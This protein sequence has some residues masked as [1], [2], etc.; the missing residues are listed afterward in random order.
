MFRKFGASEAI[1][2]NR[3]IGFMSDFF[4]AFNRVVGHKQRAT[5]AYRPQEND[6]AERMVHTLTRAIKMYVSD[7]NHRDS[8]KYAERFT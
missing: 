8:N 6:T 4:R 7:E 1:H 2:H 5:M 3:E